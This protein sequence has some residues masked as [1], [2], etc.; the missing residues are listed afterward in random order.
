MLICIKSRILDTVLHDYT[1]Y[2]SW[3]YVQ[4]F[5]TWVLDEARGLD[6]FHETGRGPHINVKLLHLSEQLGEANLKVITSNANTC[7]AI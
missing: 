6:K 1:L 7:S 4:S 2:L 3:V 5:A